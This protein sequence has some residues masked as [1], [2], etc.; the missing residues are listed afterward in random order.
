[1]TPA[2]LA[3]AADC[4]PTS[5]TLDAPVPWVRSWLPPALRQQFDLLPAPDAHRSPASDSGEEQPLAA[6]GENDDP[7]FCP[8]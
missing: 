7:A 3:M 6:A 2:A 5:P 8:L 4:G 1:M